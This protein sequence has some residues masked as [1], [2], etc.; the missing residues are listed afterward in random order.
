MGFW[1]GV[2]DWLGLKPIEDAGDFFQDLGSVASMGLYNAQNN[3][4]NP[5]AFLGNPVLAGVAGAVSDKWSDSVPSTMGGITDTLDTLREEDLLDYAG[6][7]FQTDADAA[8]DQ[9]SV[10]DMLSEAAWKRSEESAD[11]AMRRARELRQ[12]YA[13]DLMKG[14]KDAGL[15]PVLAAS[16]GFGGVS[17]SAPQGTSQAAT[18]S[19]A[20]GLNAANLMQAIASILSG[21]GSL[22]S[23]MNPLKGITSIDSN[24]ALSR[25]MYSYGRR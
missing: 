23:G 1:T 25:S 7:L 2:A 24:G 9:A 21:A 14:Y 20:D 5:S 17:S 3:S 13:A 22:I 4:F 8:L 16:G 15:N 19:K 10:N 11:R 6:N 12:T 18:S